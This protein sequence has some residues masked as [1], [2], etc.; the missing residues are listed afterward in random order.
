MTTQEERQSILSKLN[1]KSKDIQMLEDIN[2]RQASNIMKTC[3][4]SF[5]GAIFGRPNFITAIS[6]FRYC[7]CEEDY[8]LY[9]GTNYK[10]D[11]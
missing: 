5:N 11:K 4:D 9:H 8:K 1:L 7:G 6:Y 3:R 2:F 10:E